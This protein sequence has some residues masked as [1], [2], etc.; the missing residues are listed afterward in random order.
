VSME[1]KKKPLTIL[2]AQ[3]QIV[4]KG[5]ALTGPHRQEGGTP[6]VQEGG[7][8]LKNWRVSFLVHNRTG[9]GTGGTKATRDPAPKQRGDS[10]TGARPPKGVEA[11]ELVTS[12]GGNK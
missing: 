8:G 10:K 9:P 7:E 3:R 1:R 5:E 6:F 2:Q 4:G 11:P 12:R